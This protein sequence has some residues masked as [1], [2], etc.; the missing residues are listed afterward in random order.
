MWQDQITVTYLAR[1]DEV[2]AHKS[3][4]YEE[5]FVN[6]TVTFRER[7]QHQVEGAVV[8]NLQW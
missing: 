7:A 2:L 6:D 4:L 3:A 5:K 1:K 8:C